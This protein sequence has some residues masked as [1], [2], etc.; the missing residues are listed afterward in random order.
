MYI[1]FRPLALIINKP[2]SYFIISN[3][4]SQFTFPIRLFSLIPKYLPKLN[5]V[6]ISSPER[7]QTS[8]LI[9]FFY[10]KILLI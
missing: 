4:S 6:F 3:L 7:I 5:T 2:F 10:I 9:V 1:T 8:F